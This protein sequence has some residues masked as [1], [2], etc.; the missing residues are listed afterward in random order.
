[1]KRTSIM[2]VSFFVFALHPACP[3][4]ATKF[5]GRITMRMATSGRY[6]PHGF[7]LQTSGGEI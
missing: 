6:K 5:A 1:M 4:M 7:G 3:P 2:A